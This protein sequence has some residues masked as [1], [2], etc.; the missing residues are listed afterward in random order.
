MDKVKVIT[1]YARDKRL[2]AGQLQKAGLDKVECHTVDSFQG[3]EGEV[4]VLVLCVS[5][6]MGADFI[7][8]PKRLNVAITRQT[9]ALLV[10]GD[11]ETMG[12]VDIAVKRKVEGD[13]GETMSIRGTAIKSMLDW[14][15][16]HGRVVHMDPG[17]NPGDNAAQA[18]AF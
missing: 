11:I 6:E 18:F 13:H 5:R 1:M 8:N 12:K 10:I 17:A 2:L 16:G 9:D 4:I 7:A 3:R 14:F 15:R